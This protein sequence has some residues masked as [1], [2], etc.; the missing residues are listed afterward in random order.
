MSFSKPK[1][2]AI[3]AA[4]LASGLHKARRGVVG[5]RLAQGKRKPLQ[6]LV[7]SRRR[8]GVFGKRVQRSPRV[9]LLRPLRRL[10]EHGADAQPSLFIKFV[11]HRAEVLGDHG[12]FVPVSWFILGV[13]YQRTLLVNIQEIRLARC[14][15]RLIDDL[16]LSRPCSMT[17]LRCP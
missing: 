16:P 5:F 6:L 17:A 1:V 14:H 15:I 2:A 10:C 8:A 12:P 3:R 9:W 4:W 13:Q 11:E 7:L